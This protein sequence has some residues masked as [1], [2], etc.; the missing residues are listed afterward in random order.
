LKRFVDGIEVELDDSSRV[1]RID[2][3]L[4]VHSPDGAFTAVAIRKGDA[5]LVSY[6]GSEYRIEKKSGRRLSAGG[7]SSGEIR[8]PMPGLIVDVRSEIGRKVEKGDTLFVLEAMKT[9][10]PFHSPIDG[11]VSEL[12]VMVGD[13]VSEGEVLAIIEAV[14]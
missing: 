13:Q 12:N 2:D 5:I 10:Q 9:Q 7:A 4:M 1:D 6:K 8:A 14:E 11:K 3:R